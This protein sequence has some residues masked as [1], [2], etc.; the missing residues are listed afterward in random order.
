HQGQTHHAPQQA[1]YMT[2]FSTARPSLKPLHLRA[3]PYMSVGR[4]HMNQTRNVLLLTFSVSLLA[5]CPIYHV[6]T[7]P[8]SSQLDQ[9]TEI[10]VDGVFVHKP[11]GFVFP[12][13][14]NTF[15]RLDVARFDSAGLDVGINYNRT[16]SACPIA[17]TIYVYPTPRMQFIGADPEVAASIESDWLA[18]G[19]AAAEID[20]ERTHPGIRNVSEDPIGNSKWPGRRG[21]FKFG[22]L[23]PELLLFVVDRAWYLKY[24]HTYPTAC[25]REAENLLKK[26]HGSLSRRGA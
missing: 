26:F 25:R 13:R 11:S 17:A 14:V 23:T 6:N 22:D 12:E 15:E 3:R 8:Q 20:V 21:I 5:A 2:A 18:N 10:S 1:A 24:R 19:Y 7:L 4:G 16:V 9:P